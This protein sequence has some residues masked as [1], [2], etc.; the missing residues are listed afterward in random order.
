MAL[1]KIYAKSPDPAL[2]KIARKQE[3]GQAQLARIAHVNEVIEHLTLTAHDDNTAALAADLVVG[4]L[5]ITT[6]AGAAP[7]DAAGIV[8]QVV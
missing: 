1:S 3:Y 4:D 6:G 2:E 7:L 8:M 5:Y